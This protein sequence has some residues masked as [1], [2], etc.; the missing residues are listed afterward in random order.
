MS[1]DNQQ[2]LTES[3][4]QIQPTNRSWQQPLANTVQSGKARPILLAG[5]TG[6]LLWLCFYPA[7]CGWL[8]WVA[9]VPLLCLLRSNAPAHYIYLAAW[10]G[11]LLHYGSVLQWLRVAD[12]RMY[13]TWAALAFYCSLYFPAGVYLARWLDRRTGLPLVLT[14]PVV[15]TAL[16]Y[17][18]GHFGTG[19]PWYFLAH[20]QHDLLPVIQTADLAGAYAVSF[21]VAAVNALVFECLYASGRFRAWLRLREP[22]DSY[23]T[24]SLL[25]QAVAVLLLGCAA[26]GYGF[27][28]LGQVDFPNGPRVALIQ[29]NLPQHIRNDASAEQQNRVDDNAEPEH[30]A[31]DKVRRHYR[32]LCDAA[33]EQKPRPDLIV[34]PETSFPDVWTDVAPDLPADRIPVQWRQEVL[35]CRELARV[36]V[37]AWKTNVLLGVNRAFLE[38][39]GQ[40]S[41]YNSAVLITDSG[42]VAGL[43]DKVHRVPFGE[44][45]PLRDWLPWMDA[46]APYDFDY[47]IKPGE[48]LTRFSLGQYRFGVVICFEDTDPFLA[49]QYVGS[50][51][52]DFLLNISNDG[53]FD[54][55][56]EHEQH[57]AICRFRAIECRRAVARAV[58]MGISAVI[59]GNGRVIALPGPSWAQS[60]KIAAV[61]TAAIPLDQ[62]T[63]LYARWGDWLP[64]SCWLILGT[65]VV[66]S[67]V[68]PRRA[69]ARP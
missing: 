61:L 15:W 49:R 43:Y 55:T 50:D 48:N 3:K 60:K 37:R 67:F 51:P 18:R 5:A 13:F 46:F 31:G 64:W 19:F 57:L 68:W 42:Q 20:T 38:S 29:G 9:L 63:S 12:D 8:A 6:V 1:T 2:L 23:G 28:R 27:W 10:T 39:G 52:V 11:G 47:S 41:S 32:K 30:T 65:G 56:S 59:D 69:P 26:L 33:S 14:F 36:L 21:L 4:R 66:W 45:V 16:E 24:R 7:N 40:P 17:F 22:G 62:R 44:Y 35:G 58:N 25:R 54:D 53:W 34:W